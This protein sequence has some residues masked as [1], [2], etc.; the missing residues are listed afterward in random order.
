MIRADLRR[1]RDRFADSHKF[2]RVRGGYY[3]VLRVISASRVHHVTRSG[4]VRSVRSLACLCA[5]SGCH[6]A[7]EAHAHGPEHTSGAHPE[8]IRSTRGAPF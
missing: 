1:I 5:W 2:A 6:W 4:C 8:H 3:T 7:C